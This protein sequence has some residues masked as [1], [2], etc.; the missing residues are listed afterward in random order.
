MHRSSAYNLKRTLF[1]GLILLAVLGAAL[2]L[3]QLARMEGSKEL[4]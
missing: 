3:S 4:H 2:G 1:T